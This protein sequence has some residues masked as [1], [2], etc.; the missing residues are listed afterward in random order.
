MSAAT[1][2]RSSCDQVALV[3]LVKPVAPVAPVALTW[4]GFGHPLGEPPEGGSMLEL[5]MNE[6][7]QVRRSSA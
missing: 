2:G 4:Y 1:L 3:A 6:A 7:T 5:Q